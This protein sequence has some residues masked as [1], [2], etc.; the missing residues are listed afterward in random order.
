MDVVAVTTG[1][2]YMH[3][4]Q[5]HIPIRPAMTAATIPTITPGSGWI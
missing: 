5:Q 3:Q 2:T 4:I 1:R